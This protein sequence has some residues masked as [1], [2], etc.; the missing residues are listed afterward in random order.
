MWPT[1]AAWDLARLGNARAT[2]WHKV[3][4]IDAFL[5]HCDFIKCIYVLRVSTTHDYHR[6]APLAKAESSQ[7]V[8]QDVFVTTPQSLILY[9]CFTIEFCEDFGRL[10]AD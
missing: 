10:D 4:Y 6:C 3:E 9:R 7:Q 1:L 8:R 5:I 2:R